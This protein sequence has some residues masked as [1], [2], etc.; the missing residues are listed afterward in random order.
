MQHSHTFVSSLLLFSSGSLF[1]LLSAERRQS[2]SWGVGSQSSSR[3]TVMKQKNSSLIE[4]AFA[5]LL[6]WLFL[7]LKDRWEQ[8]QLNSWPSG[9]K[10]W[11]ME[12]SWLVWVWHFCLKSL[13]F[14]F[15]TFQ[16]VRKWCTDNPD[17]CWQK[18]EQQWTPR[19]GL[20]ESFGR[21]L[22]AVSIHQWA[23]R[24]VLQCVGQEG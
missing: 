14:R 7:F 3:S 2:S 15:Y 5:R 13:D 9:S 12:A 19:S 16:S 4:N 20:E 1:F 11:W 10:Y 6:K 17:L 22:C 18:T 24:C 23:C 21:S 8:I